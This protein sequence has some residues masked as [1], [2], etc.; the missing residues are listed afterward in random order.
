MTGLVIFRIG[1]G[2]GPVAEIE[3]APVI[4]VGLHPGLLVPFAP[5][6]KS[7]THHPGQWF[8]LWVLWSPHPR[9]TDSETVEW[10]PASPLEGA[11]TQES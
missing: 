1:S 3:A 7:L 6:R 4:P 5:D 2:Q 9:A 11:D 8:S 10:S